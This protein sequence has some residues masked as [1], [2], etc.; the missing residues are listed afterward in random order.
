V[1]RLSSAGLTR[2]LAH[3]WPG[4]VREL[5]NFVERAVVLSDGRLLDIDSTPIVAPGAGGVTR[6]RSS[7]ESAA[8]PPVLTLVQAEKQAILTA[9]EAAEGRI[10]GRGGAA[11]LLD[12]KPSTLYSRMKR[13][14][15]K[16]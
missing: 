3:D 15:V 8:G 10:S 1:T 2:L 4:N 13:L 11:E 6:Q 16:R 12:V 14:G 9:L 7:P 5:R